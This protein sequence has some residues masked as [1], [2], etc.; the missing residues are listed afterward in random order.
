MGR[1]SV[2]GTEEKK[3]DWRGLEGSVLGKM[4]HNSYVVTG[5]PLETK[6]AAGRI[7]QPSGHEGKSNHIRNH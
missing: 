5:P 6:S 3:S 7:G 4:L 2:M 1:K